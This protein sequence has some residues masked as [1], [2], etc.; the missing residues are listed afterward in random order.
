M[1]P[2]EKCNELFEKYYECNF[3]TFGFYCKSTA[4]KCALICVDEILSW[5]PILFWE[6]VKTEIEK[7]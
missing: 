4:K 1:T 3:Y 2:K 5:N 6:T 7:L